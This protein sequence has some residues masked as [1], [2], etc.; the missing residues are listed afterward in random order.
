M[1]GREIRLE[2][3][4]CGHYTVELDGWH[5]A[6]HIFANPL[7]DFGVDKSAA[8]VRYLAPGVHEGDLELRDGET[9]FLEGGAVLY[10]SVT[11][12][13][14]KNVRIV[15]YG[16]IDGSREVRTDETPLLPWNLDGTEDL[17]DEAAL[18]RHLSEKRVL[19][20]CVRLYSCEN[21]Q[22]AGVITRDSATFSMIFA[23]CAASIA[24]GPKPSACGAITATASTFSTA[25]MCAWPT[26][27]CG[28][29]TIAWF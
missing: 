27:F 2:I 14:K 22:V 9:L 28:I 11:A 1:Q 24:N 29:L 13:H 3:A 8:N 5:H 16:V 18:R 4:Q 15:G 7:T 12:I 10:G 19:K 6:L 26:A 25:T 20:G 17:R 21:C 23:D